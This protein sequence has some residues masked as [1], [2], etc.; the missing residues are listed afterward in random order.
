M[1]EFDK[2]ICC[3]VVVK[4]FT[5]QSFGGDNSGVDDGGEGDARLSSF[6]FFWVGCRRG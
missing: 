5:E 3:E 1:A 4:S 6:F 2:K